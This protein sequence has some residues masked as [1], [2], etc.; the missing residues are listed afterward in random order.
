[1]DSFAPPAT[2]YRGQFDGRC[3]DHQE[4]GAHVSRASVAWITFGGYPKSHGARAWITIT[5]PFEP[6]RSTLML[7]TGGVDLAVFSIE[8][9]LNPAGRRFTFPLPPAVL[10]APAMR[11][12]LTKESGRVRVISALLEIEQ[13]L[14]PSVD[15]SDQYIMSQ[16]ASLGCD[17]ELGFAQRA[18]GAEP[19]GLFRFAGTRTLFNLV[20]H[21]D[22]RF[23]DI[24]RPGCL[25]AGV[26]GRDEGAEWFMGNATRNYIFH[27]WQ[28]PSSIS[29]ED[30]IKQTEVKLGFLVRSLI[31]DIE[32]GIKIFVY[33]SKE[34]V[35][36]H[37]ILSLHRALNAYGRTKLF[38]VTEATRERPSGSVMWLARDILHG[39]LGGLL[40]N[41]QLG[42][43]SGWISL[44]RDAHAVFAQA[45]GDH[46]VSRTV[47]EIPFR[48]PP[49]DFRPLQR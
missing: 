29:R 9:R 10:A 19:L 24:V 14:L 39:F 1:M 35:D 47:K 45:R 40:D 43:G 26:V 8:P 30:I 49:P 5:T 46:L 28:H 11:C 17:C 16:F 32:D 44:C 13:D 38:W 34:F 12:T 18:A 21:L 36:Q 41:G 27:T 31:E 6:E 33:K 15:L 3:W 23:A 2:S 42:N 7:S 25:H 22:T 48:R 20:H 4:E 37:E